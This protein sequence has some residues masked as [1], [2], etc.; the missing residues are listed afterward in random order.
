ML[1]NGQEQGHSECCEGHQHVH[2]AGPAQGLQG[3]DEQQQ[4][5]A[6]QDLA[7]HHWLHFLPECFFGKRIGCRF[8]SKE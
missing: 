6:D 1:A 3:A 7:G 8:L 4:A 5:Q 2:V